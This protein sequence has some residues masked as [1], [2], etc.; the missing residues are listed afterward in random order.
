MQISW[1]N[2]TFSLPRPIFLVIEDVG[3][4]E[5]K[6]GSANNQPYR[7][8]FSRRHC[9]D[10][11]RA[12]F[13]LGKKLNMR[14]ALG[15]VLGEW[16][17][18]NLLK[19]IVGATWM[20]TS[21][22]N[23][24]NQGKWLDETAQYLCDHLDHLEI[25]LH[26]LCHEFWQD[27]L[28]ARSEF[29]DTDGTMRQD[30]IVRSHIEAFGTLLKQNNLPVFPRLFIPPA[31]NHSF[32][33]G[34]QSMQA[35]L[36]EYGIQYVVTD[37][38][39]ARQYSPPLYKKF[40]WECEVGL[41][42]RGT[43]P[44]PWNQPATRP[45]WDFTNS[46]LPLHWSNLLHPDPSQNDAVI[47]NWADFLLAAATRPDYIL[48]KDIDTC[49]RQT[50]VSQLGILQVHKHEISIDLHMIPK[51]VPFRNRSFFLKMQGNLP[52]SLHSL[53]CKGAR[54]SSCKHDLPDLNTLCISPE[55]GQDKIILF[56]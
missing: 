10:D 35:L 17:R 55:N 37:F 56:S 2:I 21:W 25:A 45:A 42:E 32:G 9:L 22:D 51:D 33:N 19:D 14:L 47:D 11:Y 12:L 15:M 38:S 16:D 50:V 31:L 4:W 3:W 46:I 30:Q 7:T 29:H 5:G 28:M 8:G 36:H 48:A 43:A 13:R 6:D 41:L 27:G 20:G 49:W 23:H 44:V 54:I 39:R 18:S 52:W 53:K 26:G 24:I 40:T 1:N 34:K